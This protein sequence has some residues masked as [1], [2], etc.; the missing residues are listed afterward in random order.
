VYKVQEREKTIKTQKLVEHADADRFVINLHGLHNALRIKRALPPEIYNRRPLSLNR[1]DVFHSA[2]SKLCK[3][4][5]Q[6]TKLAAAKKEAKATIAAALEDTDAA[7]AVESGQSIPEPSSSAPAK[8]KGAA[9]SSGK[10]KRPRVS[11]S[12]SNLW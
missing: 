11:I 1:D 10:S 6:K 2:V 7:P 5:Q 3:D 8:R 4:K 12:T 9:P